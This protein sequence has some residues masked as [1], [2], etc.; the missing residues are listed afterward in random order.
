EQEALADKYS[1]FDPTSGEPTHDKEGKLLEGKAK[2]KARKDFEKAVKVREP[3]TKKLAEDPQAL[4]S[5][6][7][8]LEDLRKQ[9]EALST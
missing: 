9:L 5:M 1:Q 8:E 6:R 4:D 2:D 3:L 7:A